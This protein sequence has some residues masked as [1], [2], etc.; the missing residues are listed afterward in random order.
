MSSK[1]TL[2][3]ALF[4]CGLAAACGGEEPAALIPVEPAPHVEPP[5]IPAPPSARQ[6]LERGL[7][8]ALSPAS[9]V[10]VRVRRA[11]EI[12]EAAPAVED[13]RMSVRLGAA[14]LSSSGLSVELA[15][16]DISP[17]SF[18]PSGLHLVD[19]RAGLA[20]EAMRTTWTGTASADFEATAQ[21][22]VDWSMR[23]ESGS[24]AIR[25]LQVGRL[26][27]SG[28][29]WLTAAD[30]V[31]LELSAAAPGML[32]DVAGLAEVSDL[33]LALALEEPATP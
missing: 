4:A 25:P 6:R 29:L 12:T 10:R 24:L 9:E 16:V 17:Q 3:V 1:I 13:G 18:P 2:A 5:V 27:V 32:F 22:E 31:R 30:Q 15:D 11:E 14:G 8:L 28:A 33:S 20:L 26:P 19:I 23:T 7:L 21:L